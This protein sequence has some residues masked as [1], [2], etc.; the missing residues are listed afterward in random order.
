MRACPPVCLLLAP[1]ETPWSAA[2]ARRLE[3]QAAPSCIFKPTV[4]QAVYWLSTNHS[5]PIGANHFLSLTVCGRVVCVSNQNDVVHYIWEVI[6]PTVTAG[7]SRGRTVSSCALTYRC[8]PRITKL[9]T[10]ASEPAPVSLFFIHI[11][12]SLL[13]KQPS[14]SEAIYSTF[15]HVLNGTIMRPSVPRRTRFYYSI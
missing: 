3:G 1:S 2:S 6:C 10:S 9:S 15:E 13:W 7:D 14:G 5:P 11:Q 4:Q 8:F 12:P